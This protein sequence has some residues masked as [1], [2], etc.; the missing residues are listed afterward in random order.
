MDS[1][2]HLKDSRLTTFRRHG[3]YYARLLL[4]P[5]KYVTR[6][7]KTT[8]EEVQ[9]NHADGCCSNWSTELSNDSRQNRNHLNSSL[10]ITSATAGQCAWQDVGWYA[11][12]DQKRFEVLAGTLALRLLPLIPFNNLRLRPHP[13]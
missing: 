2:R 13:H 1:D 6:S 11:A 8:V 12:S 7:L 9:F 10:T 5:R 4:S 3:E